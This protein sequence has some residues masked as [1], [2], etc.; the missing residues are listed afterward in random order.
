M[1]SAMSPLASGF[2]ARL[3]ASA[4]SRFQSV[5]EQLDAP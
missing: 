1:A 4:M 5:A 3:S 2:S